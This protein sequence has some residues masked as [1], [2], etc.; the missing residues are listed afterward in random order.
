MKPLLQIT[1]SS[2][3][4]NKRGSVNVERSKQK[5]TVWKWAFLIL[6][7]LN[8]GAVVWFVLQLSPTETTPVATDPVT[9]AEG[10]IIRLQVATGKGE[11]EDI[12]NQ[13]I[14]NNQENADVAYEFSLEEAAKLNGEVEILGFTVPFSLEMDPYVLENG[15]LQLRTTDL[16]VGRLNVPIS[17]AMTQ[18]GKHLPLPDWVEMNSELKIIVVHLDQVSFSDGIQLSIERIDLERDTIEVNVFMPKEVIQ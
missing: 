9:S 16:S 8:I 6:L 4:Q 12:V 7:G 13:Y 11:V 17:F 15:N 14:Q 2:L 10:E 5:K 3:K 18:I 1:Q